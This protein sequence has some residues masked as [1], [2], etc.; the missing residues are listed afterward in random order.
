VSVIASVGLIHL[1]CLDQAVRSNKN[2]QWRPR[3]Q[4]GVFLKRLLLFLFV[5]L[6]AHLGD[7]LYWTAPADDATIGTGTF[8]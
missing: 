7:Y 5:V 8:A 2:Y 1:E 3:P 6:L 4:G